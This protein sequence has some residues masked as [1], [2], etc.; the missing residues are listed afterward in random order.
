MSNL[1][2]RMLKRELK[3]LKEELAEANERAELLSSL[4]DAAHPLLKVRTTERNSGIREMA[5]V[6]MASDWH[7]EEKVTA[8]SVMGR[9][10]YSLKIADERIVRFFDAVIWAVQHHRASKKVVIRD[11]VFAQLGDL[12]TGYIHEELQEENALSPVE[13]L[14]WLQPRLEAGI[15]RLLK[16]LDPRSITIPCSHGN[17]GRTT[18]LRRISTGYSNSF[19]WLMYNTMRNRNT[20]PRVQFH[21]TPSAHQFVEV[22]DHILHFTHGDEVGLKLGPM[23]PLTALAKRIDAWDSVHRADV[24]HMGHFHRLWDLGNTVINGSLIGYN[25]FAM[26]IGAKYAPPLQAFYLLDSKRGKCA[27]LPL[28]VGEK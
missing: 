26:S 23:P 3:A 13:T 12:I 25:A 6:F 11:L 24:H 2:P 22:Y 18:P 4:N 17:H 5:A 20:D 7:V 14:L 27:E 9:N 8:A 15:K 28:W 1:D 10:R 19:E 16:E 21:V